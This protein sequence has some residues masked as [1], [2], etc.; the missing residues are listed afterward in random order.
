MTINFPTIISGSIAGIGSILSFIAQA[1]PSL[2]NEVPQLFPE[3]QRGT[4]ALWL[5][6]ITVV[7]G[8]YALHSASQAPTP[9]AAPATPPPVVPK[10]PPAV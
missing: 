9:P 2:Q 10:Q 6:V 4:I 7:A 8:I 3:S 1:A 5:H